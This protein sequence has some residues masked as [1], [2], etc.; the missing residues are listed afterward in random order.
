[1]QQNIIN[2]VQQWL[3][4]MDPCEIEL[5]SSSVEKECQQ[6]LNQI[7]EKIQGWAMSI[8]ENANLPSAPNEAKALLRKYDPASDEGCAM[9]IVIEI[10]ALQASVR[11]TDSNTAAITGMKLFEAIWNRAITKVPQQKRNTNIQTNKNNLLLNQDESEE[12]IQL[13]QATINELKAKYPHCNIN[14]LRLL[15]STRLNVTKQQLDDLDIRP[16]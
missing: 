7:T 1:M 13:Y 6:A 3:P 5:D 9:Q 2:E 8:L 12:N 16:Q 14:A 15:A 11:N 10:D 4:D